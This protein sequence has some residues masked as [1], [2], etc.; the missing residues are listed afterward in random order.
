MEPF[1]RR[2][3]RDRDRRF[4]W[5]RKFTSRQEK[6][7]RS[8]DF[9]IPQE[10]G[11]SPVEAFLND[12]KLPLDP[13]QY[14]F[15]ALESFLKGVNDS[16]LMRVH[17]GQ[18]QKYGIALVDERSDI[19]GW[20]SA[21]KHHGARDWDGYSQYPPAGANANLSIYN[22]AGLYQRL[23]ASVSYAVTGELHQL[24]P[25][26]CREYDPRLWNAVLCKACPSRLP[27]WDFC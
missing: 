20:E 6:K 1:P 2:P 8:E 10:P 19:T 24:I 12:G 21:G 13:P 18:Q 27:K 4:I 25:Y 22:A 11:Q 9:Q 15:T 26:F 14:N 3:Y 17:S 23:Q 5:D 16:D 7:Y